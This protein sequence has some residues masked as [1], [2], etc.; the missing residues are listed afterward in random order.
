MCEYDRL[1]PLVLRRSRRG[2][3]LLL[4]CHPQDTPAQAQGLPAPLALLRVPDQ[5]LG[6]CVCD[7]GSGCC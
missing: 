5:L 4:C 6:A 1:T 3:C 7:G 2:L